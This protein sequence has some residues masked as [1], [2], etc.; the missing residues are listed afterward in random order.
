MGR[1]LPYRGDATPTPDR[2]PKVV[3]LDGDQADEI[4]EALS[5]ATTRE[6]LS[7]L[8]EEPRPASE[9]ADAAN[10]SL[11]NVKYHIEKLEGADLIEVVDTWYSSTGNEMNVYAPTDTAVVLFVGDDTGDRLP[12]ALKEFAGGI[13]V[14]GLAT[15]VVNQYVTA[16]VQNGNLNGDGTDAPQEPTIETIP[17]GGSELEGILS[18]LPNPDFIHEPALL[19]FV[20]GLL[21]LAIVIAYRY[22][23][24][25]RF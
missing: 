23:G 17:D 15:A 24:S 21:M 1:L 8:Y 4:F 10:T 25:M 12:T 2:E 9:L 5:S 11:Q 13:A 22:R 6:L 14:L 18:W 3:N 16:D 7:R 19:F 20:G